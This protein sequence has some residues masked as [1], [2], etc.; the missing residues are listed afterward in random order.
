[1]KLKIKEYLNSEI[2]TSLICGVLS[3]QLN[4]LLFD[5]LFSVVA[6]QLMKSSPKSSIV[7]GLVIFLIAIGV[8]LILVAYGFRPLISIEARNKSKRTPSPKHTSNRI[9]S[10]K[11]MRRLFLA[12]TILVD[13]FYIG[14][15]INKYVYNGFYSSPRISASRSLATSNYQLDD[16][17]LYYY[18]Y[19]N[20][21]ASYSI[22]SVALFIDIAL[23][24]VSVL[25]LVSY[26]FSSVS[27]N[28]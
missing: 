1:M 12:C 2:L 23:P 3:I 25:L 21:L 8:G 14:I 16:D 18:Y 26:H 17:F 19:Y 10:S 24:L 22:K 7:N 4:L 11:L 15:L 28:T 9:I 27:K 6:N 13:L 20:D 5:S